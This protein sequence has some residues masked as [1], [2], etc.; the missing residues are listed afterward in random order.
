MTN[1]T[2]ENAL[3]IVATAYGNKFGVGVKIG[4]SAAATNGKT[5]WIPSSVREEIDLDVVWGFLAHE[6][7]HV[8]FTDF[9]ALPAVPIEAALTNV[10]EDLRIERLMMETFPGTEK[11]LRRVVAHVFS[12]DVEQPSNSPAGLI[13]DY[14][15]ISGRLHALNQTSLTGLFEQIKRRFLAELPLG[16]YGR[17]NTLLRKVPTLQSTQA[18]VE[19]AQEVVKMLKDE[20]QQQQ[21]QSQP[22][23]S[24]AD[25]SA[26]ESE[27]S[28]SDSSLPNHSESNCSGEDGENESVDH[29]SSAD[30][31]EDGAT[32]AEAENCS[33]EQQSSGQSRQATADQIEALEEALSATNSELPSDRMEMLKAHFALEQENNACD[34]TIPKPTAASEDAEEGQAVLERA[35]RTSSRIRSELIGVV[36]SVQRQ[37]QCLARKGRGLSTAHLHRVLAGDT[38]LFIKRE[39]KVKANTAV[40]IL[41]D[42]SG[43]MTGICEQAFDAA[44]SIALALDTITGVNPAVSTFRSEDEVTPIVQHGERVRRCYPRFLPTAYGGTPMSKAMLYG[45]SELAK[46]RELRKMLI[47]VTDGYPNCR[48]STHQVVELCERHGVEMFGIGLDTDAVKIYFKNHAVIHS[49]D[50]LKGLLFKTMKNAL[51]G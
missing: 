43:S 11:T 18:A 2:L 45:L 48:D 25:A 22:S 10:F 20:L 49:A 34:L 21:Q 31:A 27:S 39:D 46:T 13:H 44:V 17:L 47:V 9:V 4:G 3:P 26:G 23:P 12:D 41:I 28:A 15:L 1:N 6:A 40:H 29:G 51:V 5:I 37:G 7:A 50:E 38:R 33:S 32:E 19:L 36:Q 24:S 30:S 42:G 8:R 14:C 16:I 35:L